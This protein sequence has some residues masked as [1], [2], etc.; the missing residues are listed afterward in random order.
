MALG[1]I[2]CAIQNAKQ[3]T[4]SPPPKVLKW[5][6]YICTCIVIAVCVHGHAGEWC[7]R[8]DGS[9]AAVVFVLLCSV[10]L[11]TLETNHR[12]EEQ[13]VSFST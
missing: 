1:N 8:L 7:K 11:R 3:K 6:I 4:S 2:I 12:L 13:L 5:V 10:G 9:L